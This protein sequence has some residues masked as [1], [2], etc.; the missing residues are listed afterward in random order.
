MSTPTA[1]VL[2]SF[3]QFYKLNPDIWRLWMHVLRRTGPDSVLWMLEF[4][5]DAVNNLV[6]EAIMMGV[7]THRIVV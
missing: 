2:C 1:V 3:N 4:D 6:E 5:G 7:G